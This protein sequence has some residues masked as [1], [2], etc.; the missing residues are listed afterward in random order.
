MRTLVAEI[1]RRAGS[2]DAEAR[3]VA[4][5]LVDANLSGHESHGV[6]LLPIYVRH[7]GEE[8][9]IPNRPAE[10]VRDDGAILLF[11]GGCGYGR[12]VA[13]EAMDAAIERCRDTGVALLALRG[14]HHIGRVGAYG[15]MALAAGMVS[16]HFVNVTDHNPSVA[17]FAGREARYST[18][19][20]CVAV[21]G[22]E[23]TPP[24]LLDMATSRIPTNKARVALKRGLQLPEGYMIDRHGRPST[25]PQDLFDTPRG[26]LLPFG[27]HKGSGLALICELLAGALTGGG[28]VQPGNP[29]RHGIVN[30]MLSIIVDPARLV[31]LDWMRAEI[32]AMIA[33]VKEAPR[34]DPEIPVLV[35]GDPERARRIE[36][37]RDGI[38]IE[39]TTWGEILDGGEQAGLPRAEALA[40]VGQG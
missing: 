22:T 39:D 8:L 33:Y 19:P 38:E 24:V 23:E 11:D 27:E 9:V 4:D 14:A 31:D 18:N 37:A 7:V 30:H 21:P 15:E 6:V 16:M 2:E 35:A 34:A 20:V 5:H 40:L 12:R 13:G 1:L 10:L 3:L 25:N 17:P 32:D 29:R 26:A 36:R 28:T